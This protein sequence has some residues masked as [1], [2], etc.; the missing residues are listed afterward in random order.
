[1]DEVIDDL[2]SLESGFNDGSVE[3]MES[4]IIMQNNVSSHQCTDFVLLTKM[5]S[6]KVLEFLLLFLI[7]KIWMFFSTPYILKWAWYF[8]FVFL[9]FLY[10]KSSSVQPHWRFCFTLH[11]KNP[12]TKFKGSQ[13]KLCSTTHSDTVCSKSLKVKEFHFDHKK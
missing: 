5:G 4:N 12:Y 3:G 11:F 9:L 6:N 10:P 1:M 13:K 2:I 8:F 7:F